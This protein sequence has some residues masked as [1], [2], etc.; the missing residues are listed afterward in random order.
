[1]KYQYYEE[2]IIFINVLLIYNKKFLFDVYDI[3][4]SC[5]VSFIKETDL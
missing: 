4:K 1:M 2:Q 5:A 3:C